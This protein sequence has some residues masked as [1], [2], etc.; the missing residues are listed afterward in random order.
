MT[1]SGCVVVQMEKN[2]NNNTVSEW[3]SECLLTAATSN[4]QDCVRVRVCVRVCATMDDLHC[5]MNHSALSSAAQDT[6]RCQGVGAEDDSL[7]SERKSNTYTE[8]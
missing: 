4:T 3:S 8:L 5:A 1:L 7:V 2:S 6:N